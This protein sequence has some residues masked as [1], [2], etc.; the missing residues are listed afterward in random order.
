LSEEEY[1]I[2][3]SCLIESISFFSNTSGVYSAFQKKWDPRAVKP[4]LLKPIELVLNSKENEIFNSNS[5]E[6]IP[7]IDADIL[8]LDPPYNERQYASNY[9]I[10]ETIARYDNPVI[11]GVTGMRD[12]SS[13]KSSFCNKN[14]AL[15][16]LNDIAK[17]A[18]YKYLLLSYNTEG[19]MSQKN[20]AEILN[21]YGAVELVEFEY[22]RFKSNNK[23]KSKTKKYIQEQ[24]Y[25][26]K[27]Y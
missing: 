13:Q 9:H 23:G 15:K 2:L 17:N 26:V 20:I 21:N 6:L 19:I 12:Y 5:M 22:L 3:L 1:F 16:S 7:K 27:K 18:K 14:T 24:L 8:Y 10:L 11:K 25:I 4:F